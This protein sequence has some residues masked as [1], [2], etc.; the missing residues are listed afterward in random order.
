MVPGAR[1]VQSLS[2]AE[3]LELSS[4]GAKKPH[5]GTLG[6]AGRAGVPIRIL[7]SR[8]PDP[9]AQGTLIGRRSAAPPTV[10]SIACRINQHLLYALPHA[11]GALDGLLDSV[12]AAAAP[13]RP[14]LLP[15]ALEET[16]L[17]L[18]LD[19]GDRLAEIEAALAAVARVGVV[20]GQTIVSVISEDLATSPELAERVLTAAHA[21][22][23]QLVTRGVACP[24]VRFPVELEDLPLVIADLHDR[25]FAGAG[26]SV[27]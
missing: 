24:V 10:K 13:F 9:D 5:F 25:L 7:N 6:P 16:S 18:A 17:R 12:L 21:Y 15:F 23:P 2:F 8:R 20:H 22:R 11:G 1:R 4:S 27:P 3:S 14:A 19:R 26:E